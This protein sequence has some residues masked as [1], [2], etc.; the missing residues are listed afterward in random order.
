MSVSDGGPLCG[1]QVSS[2]SWSPDAARL[3]AAYSSLRFQAGAGDRPAQAFVWDV[4][5]SLQQ[6][7]QIGTD[8]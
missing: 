8:W 2:L 1:G 3:A 4:G 6:V 7:A 5:Q